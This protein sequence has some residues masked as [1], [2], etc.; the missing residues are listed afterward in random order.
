MSLYK[1]L[2]YG[3]QTVG[4]C[5]S[6]RLVAQIFGFSAWC[7]VSLVTVLPAFAFSP[8]SDRQNQGEWTLVEGVSDEFNTTKLDTDKW[9]IQGTDGEYRSN[10]I[11][12]APSQFSTDNVRLEGGQLK[13]EARWDPSFDFS[14]K[15]DLSDSKAPNGRKY[16]NITTAAV[17]SKQRVRYG[18]FEIRCKAARASVT[19]SFWMTGNSSELDVFEFLGRPAQRHKTHLESELWSSIHDWSKPGGPT[20]WTDRMQLGF[21]VAEGVHTY[22]LEWDP[23][24]LKFFVD[25]VMV[26]EVTKSQVGDE[27]WVIDKP[28][29]VWVDSEVFPWHGIPVEEDLPVDY[30][31]DYIRIWQSAKVSDGGGLLGFE[32]PQ[33]AAPGQ[34]WWIPENFRKQVALSEE[35]ASTGERSLR[36]K[37]SRNPA[38]KVTAFTPYGSTALGPGDHTFSMKVWRSKDSDVQR[39][40]V[41][42]E[43]PWLEL[44]PIDL[45]RL[46][47]EQW[48]TVSQTFRRREAS[49]GKDRVRVSLL[50]EDAGQGT[51]SVHIDDLRLEA[52]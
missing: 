31:V 51:G 32:R 1:S 6:Q 8:A 36:F 4:L 3:C 9:H 30:E 18:Y 7:A 44:K 26:R 20:T 11:G 25:G 14:P 50:K 46:P 33:G 28:V 39:L 45:T 13:L 35:R 10:F 22:G 38:K 5:S 52:N 27:G 21:K 12:R 34:D 19:S 43:E 47:E 16:E 49:G 23:E 41:T 40:R 29:W 42:L 48:T 15:I 2:F 24:Y 37:P 17:I